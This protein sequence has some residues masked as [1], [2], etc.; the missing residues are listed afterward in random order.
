ME[1]IKISSDYDVT[2]YGNKFKDDFYENY[3]S[4]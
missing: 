4:K 2:A 1:A 3:F